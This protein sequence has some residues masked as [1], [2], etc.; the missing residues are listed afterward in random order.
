M[1]KTLFRAMLPIV[2]IKLLLITNEPQLPDYQVITLL[3]VSQSVGI[4]VTGQS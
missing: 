2:F 1:L 3:N 4:Y